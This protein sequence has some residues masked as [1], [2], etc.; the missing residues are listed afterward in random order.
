LK[1]CGNNQA[2]PPAAILIADRWLSP[3]ES[4]TRLSQ[5]KLEL[6]PAPGLSLFTNRCYQGD[7]AYVSGH[8]PL[9]TD[10]RSA[11]GRSR[12]RIRWAAA[13]QTGLAIPATLRA[14]GSSPIAARIRHGELHARF[15]YPAVINGCS[16]LFVMFGEENGIGAQCRGN[17]SLPEIS[18]WRSGHFRDS[19]EVIGIKRL[20]IKITRY[21]RERRRVRNLN[22]VPNQVH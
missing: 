20:M 8:G 22:L 6:P 21:A 9:K 15:R 5:L 13:R 3:H 17:G 4:E 12:D 19:P 7:L 2:R 1:N 18:R 14:P 16:E 11:A 10:D